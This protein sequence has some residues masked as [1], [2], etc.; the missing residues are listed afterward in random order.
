MC[1]QGTE[2]SGEQRDTALQ[3]A[4]GDEGED[5]TFSHCT[6]HYG[7]DD[8][9]ENG[10]RDQDGRVFFDTVLDRADDCH[11]ADADGEGRRNEAVDKA[12]IFGVACFLLQPFTEAFKASFDVDDLT[13][14]RAE[15]KT[16][17]DQHRA[18]GDESSVFADGKHF[19]KHTADRDEQRADTAGFRQSVLYIFF[20]QFSKKQTDDTAR[21]DA[22]AVDQCSESGHMRLPLN[23]AANVPSARLRYRTGAAPGQDRSSSEHRGIPSYL[24]R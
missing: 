22:E 6:G 19:F 7:D 11:R 5:A 24:H 20:D 18:R 23:T 9:V 2:K 17:D 21:K 16:N 13:E 4:D 12:L 1:H 15:R 3:N 8:E 10:F 14:E